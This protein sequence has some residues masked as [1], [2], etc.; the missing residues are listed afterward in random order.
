MSLESPSCLISQLSPKRAL[1][2]LPRLIVESVQ[3]HTLVIKSP[4]HQL[5]LNHPLLVVV[6]LTKDTTRRP[7][8]R[9]AYANQI[10]MDLF[11]TENTALN[12]RTQLIH[13]LGATI[14]TDTVTI[15]KAPDNILLIAHFAA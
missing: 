15:L 2:I 5:Q 11:A 10:D 4:S 12:V 3:N 9:L 13:A 1:S 6:N 14:A 7:L 8:T